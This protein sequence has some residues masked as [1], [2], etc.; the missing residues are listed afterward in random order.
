MS[1]VEFIFVFLGALAVNLVFD[2]D[3]K[4]IAQELLDALDRGKTVPSIVSRYPG[5]DSDRRDAGYQA[6]RS[7]GVGYAGL[8]VTG[9][10]LTLTA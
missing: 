8:P 3:T 1:E 4:Q 6:W 2:M 10:Q 7:L 9:L 5:F